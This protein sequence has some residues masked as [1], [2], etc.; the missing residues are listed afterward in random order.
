MTEIAYTGNLPTMIRECKHHKET[1]FKQ[2]S[3]GK[4]VCIQCG[5]DRTVANRVK[6]KRILMEER[7]GKC[8][9]CG[10]SD[11]RALEWHHSDPLKG[12]RAYYNSLQ[13]KSVEEYRTHI[14]ECEL[15]C[16]NCHR[17]EHSSS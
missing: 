7:G 16:A 3:Q 17:I 5:K 8:V 9:R 13:D 4:W 11:V 1:L 10:F 14:S 12:N 15:I 6:K 2:N